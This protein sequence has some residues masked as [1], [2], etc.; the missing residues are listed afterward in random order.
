MD[1]YIIELLRQLKSINR[2]DIADL[3][4][5]S[6]YKISKGGIKIT[7][8]EQK[9]ILIFN[10]LAPTEQYHQLL[11]LPELDNSLIA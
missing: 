11:N 8:Y 3:I 4:K 9:Q 2:Q 7:R 1:E 5:G 10:L 6:R